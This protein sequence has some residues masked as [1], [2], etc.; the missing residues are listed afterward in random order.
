MIKAKVESEEDARGSQPEIPFFSSSSR[1]NDLEGLTSFFSFS[2]DSPSYIRAARSNTR[3]CT[4]AASTPAHASPPPLPPRP[5]SKSFH[6]RHS[7]LRKVRGGAR[8]GLCGFWEKG[9][10]RRYPLALNKKEN[11]RSKQTPR[12]TCA[13]RTHALCNASGAQRHQKDK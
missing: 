3:E 1:Y 10:G 2:N 7:I 13:P 5:L 12:A 8:E 4:L 6:R 9:R 11:P